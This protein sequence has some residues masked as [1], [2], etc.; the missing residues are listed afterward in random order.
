MVSRATLLDLLIGARDRYDT[1]IAT[2]RSRVDQRPD[3]ELT[4]PE[5]TDAPGGSPFAGPMSVTQTTERAWLQWQPDRLRL[6]QSFGTLAFDQVINERSG[7]F[8]FNAG[9]WR[10]TFADTYTANTAPQARDRIS[11]SFLSYLL[12]CL[13]PAPMV[14]TLEYR[15][16][17]PTTFLG[18]ESWHVHAAFRPPPM[19]V[20][21]PNDRY[22]EGPPGFP[23]ADRFELV[24]DTERG[25][26]LRFAA[27]ADDEEYGFWEIQE[28]A[29]D[30]PLADDLFAEA[31]PPR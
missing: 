4:H 12:N 1:V 30:E 11:T 25:V 15:D 5:L 26:I 9:W 10:M 21:Y 28:I 29:Y 24:V 14:P 16:V 22:H 6:E 8:V 2:C 13:D 7:R 27:I 31:G 18:R 17:T 20:R 23:A 3:L 19:P